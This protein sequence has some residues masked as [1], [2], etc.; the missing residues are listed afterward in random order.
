MIAFRGNNTI[1]KLLK[2]TSKVNKYEGSVVYKLKCQTCSGVYIGQTGRN[3][4][5]RYKE[6][7]RDIR[8]NNPLS[9]Y[10]KWGMITEIQKIIWRW[11]KT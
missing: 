11:W 2:P 10:W 1:E 3:F 9:I 6:H 5:V 8:H 7:I 4:K